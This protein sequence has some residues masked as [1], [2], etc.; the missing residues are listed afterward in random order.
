MSIKDKHGLNI[1]KF[2]NMKKIGQNFGVSDRNL[3][4]KNEITDHPP[5][6]PP[7]IKGR[8]KKHALFLNPCYV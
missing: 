6:P 3:V 7:L 8:G 2:F 5:F 4:H 1:T